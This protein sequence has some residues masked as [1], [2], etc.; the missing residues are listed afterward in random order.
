MI[1]LALFQSDNATSVPDWSCDTPA[2]VGGRGCFTASARVVL[3][4]ASYPTVATAAAAA[5]GGFAGQNCR[6]AAFSPI[7]AV[8]GAGTFG[9][10]AQVAIGDMWAVTASYSP[11][12]ASFGLMSWTLTRGAESAAFSAL[13]ALPGALSATPSTGGT[14]HGLALRDPVAR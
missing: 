6:G 13:L 14:R 2:G 10:P 1:Y 9:S 4:L 12:N 5:G 3:H 7:Q 8:S 11:T